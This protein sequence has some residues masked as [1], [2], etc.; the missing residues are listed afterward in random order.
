[1]LA[2][3]EVYASNPQG[4]TCRGSSA[5]GGQSGCPFPFTAQ[6][7]LGVYTVRVASVVNI[8]RSRYG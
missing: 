1:M 6:I 5:P 8:R 2:L 4:M 7:V 3:S